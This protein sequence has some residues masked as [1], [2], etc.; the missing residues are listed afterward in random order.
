MVYNL[1]EKEVRFHSGGAETETRSLRSFPSRFNKIIVFEISSPGVINSVE[2]FIKNA[3]K[4]LVDCLKFR[5][6]INVSE[7]CAF[8]CIQLNTI[9]AKANIHLGKVLCLDVLYCT[10]NY[11]R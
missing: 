5:L 4:V 6:L 2:S 10:F 7:V 11:L 9:K 3:T 1:S 8:T